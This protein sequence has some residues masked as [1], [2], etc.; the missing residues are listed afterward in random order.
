MERHRELNYFSVTSKAKVTVDPTIPM[1][2]LASDMKLAPETIRMAVLML[3]SYTRISMYLMIENMKTIRLQRFDKH[4][5]FN[6]K[7]RNVVIVFT[8]EKMFTIDAVV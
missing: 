7:C 6:Q 3:R 8:D 5:S 2:L 4:L 1:N